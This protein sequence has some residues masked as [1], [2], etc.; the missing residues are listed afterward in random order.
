[1]RL[2]VPV[3]VPVQPDAET[4][5]QWVREELSDPI[6]H[7]SESLLDRLVTWVL[8]QLDRLGQAASG[9]DVR[10]ALVV[11]VGLVVVGVVIAL[12][13]TGPVRRARAARRTSRSVFTDD[14]RTTAQLR[15]SADA[16]A[17]QGLWSEAVLDRFRAILR[18]LEDR[19]LLDDRP[20]RTAHE[21][22]DEAA[23]RLPDVAADLVRAGR[24]FDDVCY[25]ELQAGPDDD[26]WLRELDQ[27][28]TATRPVSAQVA[29]ATGM[30]RPR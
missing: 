14:V 1:M 30:V 3:E 13:V 15:A 17:A 5:R 16:L 8:E 11:I 28:A 9:V 29:A 25:G 26:A 19:A 23:A 20:G 2:R 6:Y 21:A 22:A 7:E 12:V 27:R 18:S 24:L 10:T 4:A